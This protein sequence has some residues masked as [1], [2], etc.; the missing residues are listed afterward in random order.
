MASATID[1]FFDDSH[2][3]A[4]TFAQM[5]AA[6]L[7]AGISARGR[8]SIALSGGTTPETF[9]IELSTRPLDWSRV[10]VTLCDDRWVPPH[11]DRSNERLMRDTLLRNAAAPAEFV[12]LY[13]D[14]ST[15]EQA[16]I[17]LSANIARVAPPFD[18]VVLGMGDDGHTASLFPDGDH[19][20][21]ALDP[22]GSARV[23]PMRAPG[24]PEPRIT[25]T[26]P[27][28]VA[29]RA[30]YLHIEGAHKKDV[31]DRAMAADGAHRHAPIRNVIDASHVTPG[32]FWCP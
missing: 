11:S 28:L 24:A 29:T 23:S 7:R 15:P 19:L 20:P 25:L 10:I 6:N 2:A 27:A 16:L 17:Q 3:L 31:F 26:L 1:Y 12:P 9:L 5:V 22:N 18:V 32:V 21:A 30:M 4:A 13:V 14:V 8:A